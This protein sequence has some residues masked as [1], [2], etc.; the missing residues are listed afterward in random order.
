MKLVFAT[1]NKHKLE[2]VKNLLGDSFNLMTLNEIGCHEDI[3]ETA[4]TLEGNAKIKSDHVK[5]HYGYDCF[6]D[7]TGLEVEALN[8]EPG[9]YSAR[10]AGENATF[11]DNVQ[12]MLKAMSGFKNRKARFR[13][14]I[15][16]ILNGEQLFFEGICD[17]HIEASCS[18]EKGFGYDPIF[19]P[20]GFDKTFAE[21]D[22]ETKGRISHR[23]LA[24]QKLVAYLT[25]QVQT[26]RLK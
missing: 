3:E 17:G 1:N 12:K 10:Y 19:K 6:A 26:S 23:G 24:V 11:D 13:T 9:V 20:L 14:V 16:L 15:S 4:T 22:I 18:G 7:D 25:K 8:G 5:L 21:M 2:E